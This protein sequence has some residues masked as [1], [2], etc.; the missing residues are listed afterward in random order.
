[1]S[2]RDSII[3][4]IRTVIEDHKAALNRATPDELACFGEW[5]IRTSPGMYYREG[6]KTAMCVLNCSRY[7]HRMG[8]GLLANKLTDGA[9][10]KGE[11]LEYRRAL[12][13]EIESTAA[14]LA[15]VEEVV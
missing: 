8:A 2:T 11:V 1:M 7:M 4:T 6:S 3:R 12:Q 5:V 15:Q 10:N 9:G 13:A 14:L